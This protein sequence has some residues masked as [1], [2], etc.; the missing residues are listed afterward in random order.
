MN[1]LADE[2]ATRWTMSASLFSS[3]DA[4]SPTTLDLLSQELQISDLTQSERL[5]HGFIASAR[6]NATKCRLLV[7]RFPTSERIDRWMQVHWIDRL[8]Q[9]GPVAASIASHQLPLLSKGSLNTAD[10]F[11]LWYALFQYPV[12]AWLLVG[13]GEGM[14]RMMVEE[15]D[16]D[17]AKR[18]VALWSHQ[19]PLLNA[20]EQL[21]VGGGFLV[22]L[23]SGWVYR[24]PLLILEA[25][26]DK[27]GQHEGCNAQSLMIEAALDFIAAH[28]F[29]SLEVII[30][31][32]SQGTHALQTNPFAL[33][34]IENVCRYSREI[35]VE[36]A[37]AML[38]LLC[39]F[40][41]D[42]GCRLERLSAAW[43][44]LPHSSIL[45]APQHHKLPMTRLEASI[46]SSPDL[47]NYDAIQRASLLPDP[48]IIKDPKI[49]AMPHLLAKIPAPK[50]CPGRGKLIGILR[51]TEPILDICASLDRQW[52]ASVHESEICF[53]DPKAVVLG[54]PLQDPLLARHKLGKDVELSGWCQCRESTGVVLL[55]RS[56]AKNADSGSSGR[57]IQWALL[58][59]E[60]QAIKGKGEIRES[61]RGAIPETGSLKWPHHYRLASPGSSLLIYVGIGGG[62]GRLA[63]YDLD[64][65]RFSWTRGL[66]QMPKGCRYAADTCILE[67]MH[68]SLTIELASG[69]LL[70]E[71]GQDEALA[72]GSCIRLSYP[73]EMFVQ[74]KGPNIHI[75]SAE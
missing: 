19:H 72:K 67:F 31:A 10:G 42:H 25:P 36:H 60:Y 20:R 14:A 64:L 16:E 74:V 44:G 8:E 37:K 27:S 12:G 68:Q 75:Y 5:Q 63:A 66:G 47:A 59:C 33:D 2:S 61:A 53:W 9:M 28:R 15:P 30:G 22:D 73:R 35:L 71:K 52:F 70:P 38:D 45:F 1:L 50:A 65:E 23:A 18:Q 54:Q 21:G 56:A 57:G 40:G 43:Q 39:K 13:L 3:A 11:S 29:E 49:P 51:Q 7:Y 46:L 48:I 17:Y 26:L 41:G 34:F 6:S 4:T 69:D 62:R 58:D 55:T 32:F 24:D